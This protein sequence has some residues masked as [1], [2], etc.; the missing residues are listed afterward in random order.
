MGLISG[1]ATGPISDKV[2]R[3]VSVAYQNAGRLTLIINDILDAEKIESGKL[4]LD[5]ATQALAP[6]VEQ[7]VEQ[8]RGYGLA[9]KVRFELSRPM[10]EVN[11]NVRARRRTDVRRR[12]GSKRGLSLPDL[13]PHGQ[14]PVGPD[15]MTGVAVRDAFQVILVLGLGFPE[16]TDG[17]HFGH[18]LTGP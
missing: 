3:L 17:R 4:S 13:S 1:G 5:L 15:E 8:H 16:S 7:S 14:L 18:Q 12:E 9:H 6:L 11:V 10:P 2:A